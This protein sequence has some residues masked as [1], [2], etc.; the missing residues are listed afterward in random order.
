MRCDLVPLLHL[1]GRRVRIL[2]MDQ[3]QT[4]IQGLERPVKLGIQHLFDGTQVR[5]F[6]NFE[7]IPL[8]CKLEPNSDNGSASLSGASPQ[9]A[10]SHSIQVS[11]ATPYIRLS[12]RDFFNYT[13]HLGYDIDKN[14]MLKPNANNLTTLESYPNDRMSSVVQRWLFFELL[15]E[16]LGHIPGFRY[17]HFICEKISNQLST[18]PLISTQHLPAY[19]MAWE[20]VER[21]SAPEHR[22]RRF[23]HIQRVLDHARFFVRMCG[24]ES[25]EGSPDWPIDQ[26]VVLSLMVLGETLT[27]AF[28]KIQQRENINHCIVGWHDHD[29]HSQGWG[30]SKLVLEELKNMGWCSKTVRMLQGL[31]RQNTI[32]LLYLHFLNMSM[33]E[34]N[35]RECTQDRCI[36]EIT[37]GVLV[38]QHVCNDQTQCKEVFSDQEELAKIIDLDQ[39][40]LLK[41]EKQSGRPNLSIRASSPGQ[42][43]QPSFKAISHVWS[44]HFGDPGSNKIQECV[45][46]R[47][48]EIFNYIDQP[49]MREQYFWIDTLAIPVK[50]KYREQRTK[51]V[52]SMQNVYANAKCTIVLDRALMKGSLGATYASNAM[53]ITMSGW[54]RR[55][56][57]LQEAVLSKELWFDFSDHP[58]ALSDLEDAYEEQSTSIQTQLEEVAR[59]YHHG[60]LGD[61]RKDL[62]KKKKKIDSAV[63]A[64]TWKAVQWRSTARPEH[65][66]FAL[67]ILFGRDV[68]DLINLDLI[69]PEKGPSPEDLDKRMRIL[70][71][72]L[73]QDKDMIPSGIIFVPGE[74]LD[75]PGYGWATRSWLAGQ[76]EVDPPDPLGFSLSDWASFRLGQGLDVRYPGFKIHPITDQAADLRTFRNVA[77]PTNFRLVEWYSIQLAHGEKPLPDTTSLPKGELALIMPRIPPTNRKEIALLVSIEK[78][79]QSQEGEILHAHHLRRVWASHIHNHEEIQALVRKFCQRDEPVQFIGEKLGDKQKWLIDSCLLLPNIAD[80]P[81]PLD[82]EEHPGL[83]KSATFSARAKDK[84]KSVSRTLTSLSGPRL[85]GSASSSHSRSFFGRRRGEISETS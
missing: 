7:S 68:R 64:A 23:A 73:A 85:S 59:A 44:D 10:V 37:S 51:A 76:H 12:S 70:L 74:R 3:P 25:A 83:K 79:E 32:G 9:A 8:L 41:Y 36:H 63:V 75:G 50:P 58:L 46:E 33:Q 47:F 84:I 13:E 43:G 56:W 62:R 45:L 60:I 29:Y 35:H 20:S 27:R 2:P 16:C 71:R 1:S 24:V 65:E 26:K 15:R 11:Q 4:I 52:Q 14:N 21:G 57:N 22:I 66:A 39:T 72:L 78:T 6:V 77:F 18:R 31:L 53:K 17:K 80:D 69:D 30:F 82:F 67:A 42:P 34:K 5:E 49:E 40:P 55:L 19:L 48:M 61:L 81:V 54:M 38:P 28:I